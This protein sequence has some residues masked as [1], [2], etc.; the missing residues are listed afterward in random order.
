MVDWDQH[1]IAICS[2]PVSPEVLGKLFV[3]DN[4]NSLNDWWYDEKEIPQPLEVS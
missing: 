3:K 2:E 1:T 4:E